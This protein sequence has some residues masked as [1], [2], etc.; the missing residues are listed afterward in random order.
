M[1]V[2]VYPGLR[3]RDNK[4]RILELVVDS[5]YKHDGLGKY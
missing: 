3:F 4:G 5:L 1:E 2:R